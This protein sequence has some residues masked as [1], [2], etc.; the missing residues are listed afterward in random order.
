MHVHAKHAWL[1]AHDSRGCMRST[2]VT[3]TLCCVVCD[4]EYLWHMT[5][6]TERCSFPVSDRGRAL[7]QI[8][9]SHS[10][11]FNTDNLQCC[12][13]ARL[14]LSKVWYQRAHSLRTS[15]CC[16]THHKMQTASTITAHLR[17]IPCATKGGAAGAVFCQIT[18]CYVIIYA[19]PGHRGHI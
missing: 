4:I 6:F 14:A 8:S 10:T 16:P 12:D 7:Q 2:G 3:S 5:V 17:N 11:G 19:E 15:D 1:L 9:T 13:H 18:H